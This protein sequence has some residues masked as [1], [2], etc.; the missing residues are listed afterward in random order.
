MGSITQLKNEW[1]FRRIEGL[2]ALSRRHKQIY[3]MSTEDFIVAA[4]LTHG[5]RYDYSGTIYVNARTK[6]VIVCGIHGAFWQRPRNHIAGQHCPKCK[7]A[8]LAAKFS[9]TQEQ[10]ITKVKEIHKDAYDYSATKYIN[11]ASMISVC[12]P[13]HGAFSTT[14][15]MH[16]RGRGCKRCA[17]ERAKTKINVTLSE[18]LARA[19]AVHQ[20]AH[21]DYSLVNFRRVLDKIDV[22]CKKHGIFRVRVK[23]HLDGRG[24][25]IC[26]RGVL[27]NDRFLTIANSRHTVQYDYSAIEYPV[28]SRL[29]IQIGCERHGVFL[30]LAS[31]HLAGCGC[32]TCGTESIGDPI[33]CGQNQV[34]DFMR[35]L[36]DEE[37]LLS[38]RTTISPLELDIFIPR[39]KLAVE[40]HGLYWHSYRE[41]ETTAQVNKHQNKA[42]AAALAGISLKQFFEHEWLQRREI[43]CSMLRH[44][45]GRSIKIGARETRTTTISDTVAFE[46]C[47]H[48]HLQ[49]GRHASFSAGLMLNGELVAVVMLSKHKKYGHEL[50]R[51]ATK[52]GYSIAGGFSRL[53]RFSTA[54]LRVSQLFTYADMRHSNATTYKLA[55][56]EYLG[57]TRPNYFYVKGRRV[58]N[59]T[60]FQKSK[61]PGL[62]E[63]FDK[64]LSESDNMFANGYRR[65]WDAGHHKLL[66]KP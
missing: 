60:R 63:S 46:F 5:D 31:N 65:L 35:S 30:Q 55:G 33:S 2:C 9:L 47:E 29:K 24:C 64:S 44:A 66:L 45:L 3:D 11:Q 1:C 22:V 6:V 26:G 21:Y 57:Y 16:L 18:F 61:L 58:F 12:C 37:I 27:T 8:N 4:R 13:K 10:F 59:R 15:N 20:D 50:I 51:Y 49:G 23:S 36:T 25:P 14:A 38:D 17:I 19:T 39:L 56:F 52:T 42:L 48:N 54:Q 28:D 41:R 43:V 7:Y 53:L 32:P 40:Y 34:A 62:L